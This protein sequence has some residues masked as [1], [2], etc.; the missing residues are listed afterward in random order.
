MSEGS[1]A[2]APAIKPIESFITDEQLKAEQT[3]LV[4]SRSLN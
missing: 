4:S 3:Q 2:D 1:L